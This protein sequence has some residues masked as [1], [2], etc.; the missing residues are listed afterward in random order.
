MTNYTN[1]RHAAYNVTTGEILTSSTGNALKR[2][3]AS[4]EKWNC[5]HGYGRG[6]WVFGHGLDAIKKACDKAIRLL[7]YP[8]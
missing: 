6:K 2:H 4:N 3:I 7:E 5:Q 8:I 1:N